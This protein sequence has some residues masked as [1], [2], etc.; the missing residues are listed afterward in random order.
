MRLEGRVMH[1]L[2]LGDVG[3]GVGEGVSGEVVDGG[4]LG[5]VGGR[6]EFGLHGI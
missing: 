5:R 1:L 2:L 6:G 4:L 3:E